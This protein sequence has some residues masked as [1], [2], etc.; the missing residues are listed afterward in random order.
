M[1]RRA[2]EAEITRHDVNL[3]MEWLQRL[4]AKLDQIVEAVVEEDDGQD[5]MGS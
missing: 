2:P 4:D 5:E 3:I 1:F